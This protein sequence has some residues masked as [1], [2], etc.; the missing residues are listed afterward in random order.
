M[1]DG[2]EKK[3]TSTAH[4]TIRIYH[5]IGG[6]KFVACG[7]LKAGGP[8]VDGITMLDR[9]RKIEGTRA[10][11]NKDWKHLT[12]NRRDFNSCDRFSWYYLATERSTPDQQGACSSFFFHDGK[13]YQ[14]WF[15]VGDLRRANCLVL[16]RCL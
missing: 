10:I 16:R 5:T 11:D 12:Q 7:F 13:W 15:L 8:P 2:N 14:G 9:I 1:A 3:D 4:E 6:L